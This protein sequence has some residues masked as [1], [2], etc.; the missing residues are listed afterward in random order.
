M[1]ATCCR[2]DFGL[3]GCVTL[4]VGLPAV[5]LD[6]YPQPRH[7]NQSAVS[8]D[9][10]NS[11]PGSNAYSYIW[12]GKL[13]PEQSPYPALYVLVHGSSHQFLYSHD[14]V[15][16]WAAGPQLLA[17]TWS[18]PC[19]ALLSTDVSQALQAQ[20]QARQLRVQC[21]DLTHQLDAARRQA[22]VHSSR[23]ARVPCCAA[24]LLTPCFVTVSYS[25]RVLP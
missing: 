13:R 25:T 17:A 10:V 11:L 22:A 19:T 5:I 16:F 24:D 20:E 15:T 7:Y 3:K 4:H 8:V 1:A 9:A 14:V 23:S 21:R 18:K 2:C 6:D 12:L